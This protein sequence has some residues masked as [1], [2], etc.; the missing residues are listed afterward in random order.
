RIE[1]KQVG[2]RQEA[3]RLGGIGSCGREL[4]CSTWLTDF[5]SVNTSAARYQ[6][7]SLNPQKL[8]GQC[9]KL[10]CC[11]NYELDTY[12]DA[13]KGM[14]DSETKLQT[15]NGEAYCQKIDIFK[16]VMWFA[17]PSNGANWYKIE[18]PQVKEILALN[19]QGQVIENI[20]D[21]VVEEENN[22]SVQS[23][24]TTEDS[25]SRFDE[26]KRKKHAP[27]NKKKPVGNTVEKPAATV[28]TDVKR[29]PRSTNEN[30]SRPPQAQQPKQQNRP[31]RNNQPKVQNNQN[32]PNNQT[33]KPKPAVQNN[34]P[35]KSNEEG[36]SKNQARK[37]NFKRP[38][39]NNGN[40][41][42]SK[43]ND[44]KQ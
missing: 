36:A 43:P 1:M 16:Q 18:V 29:A 31:P 44:N 4:C 42:N 38:N 10:K 15:K 5:R 20:E 22:A 8:A 24:A 21:Y 41:P 12:L 39:K 14:P 17:Y 33:E 6:Q 9:G 23:V 28:A 7:L 26:P 13:L 32:N 19:K 2:F 40:N 3:A 37:K 27:R 35:V 30:A 34:A 25:L 11:L